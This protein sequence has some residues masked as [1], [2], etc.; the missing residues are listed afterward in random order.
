L[1][2][3]ADTEFDL[4][5]LTW[6]KD[7]IDQ[8]LTKGLAA[9]AEFAARPEDETP[10][11]HAQTHIHQAAGAVQIVGLDGAITVM[12]EVER[13]LTLLE[14]PAPDSLTARVEAIGAACRRLSRYLDDLTEGE[15]PLTLKLY[16]EYE[17][18]MKLRGSD[19]ASPTDLFF[20]D[21][22]RR[23]KHLGQG[24]GQ[25][26]ADRGP[27]FLR[28]QRRAYEQGLLN[29]LRG[30]AQGLAAMRQAIQEIEDAHASSPAGAFWWTVG[31]FLTSV[32]DQ[33]LL[34]GYTVKQLCARIDLQIRRFV[35][36]STKVADRLRREVLY[37][38]AISVPISK[39]VE[40]VQ[41]L[42]G[43]PAMLLQKVEPRQLDLDRFQ[44]VLKRA[45]EL[46]A[47]I[48]DLWLRFTSGRREALA[49]IAQNLGELK[50]L[51]AALQEPSLTSLVGTLEGVAV[52]AAQTGNVPDALAIEFATGLLLTEDAIGHF[53]KLS[54][55]FPR[56]VESMRRR[57]DLAQRGVVSLPTAEEDLLDDM[58]RR[59][60]ERM[61]LS[62]V[63][64]EIQGN[65][66]QIEK[67]LDAFFRDASERGELAGLGGYARQIQ[68]ALQMLGLTQASEL[69]ELCQKQIDA[70]A[71][72]ALASSDELELLAESLS[73]LGFYIEAVEQQR[74]DAGRLLEP[75]LRRRLGLAAEPAPESTVQSTEMDLVA[76]REDLP[77]ALARFRAAPQDPALRAELNVHLQALKNDA[78][79][80]ADTAFSD[81]A[82]R[83]LAALHDERTS[84]ATLL[85]ALD[86]LTPEQASLAPAPSAETMR[87]LGVGESKLDAELSEIF[88]TEAGEVLATVSEHLALCENDPQDRESLRA[89]RR[90]F[91]T[92]K[93]SGRMVGL[94]EL[95][96][97]AYMVEK[98]LNRWLD[99]ERP[100]V[101]ELLAMLHK[102]ENE[103]R[104][105]VG[106]LQRQG[107]V[108]VE[109]RALAAAISAL[110]AAHPPPAAPLVATLA[111]PAAAGKADAASA[112]T[113]AAEA[114]MADAAVAELAEPAAPAGI[115]TQIDLPPAPVE[116][117]IVIGEVRISPSL[118][119]ILLEE[120]AQH[121]DTLNREHAGLQFS[122]RAKPTQ[123]MVRAA[124]TLSG[125]YR[126]AGFLPVAETAHALENALLSLQ[127]QSVRPDPALPTLADAV[128]AL[129]ELVDFIGMRQPFGTAAL[130]RATDVQAELA[131]LRE[132]GEGA[133]VDSETLAAQA[134]LADEIATPL[135][136]PA[137]A[138]LLEVP[139]ES[140]EPAPSPV[141]A[142]P[143]A[144]AA[145]EIQPVAGPVVTEPVAPAELQ[146]API[147]ARESVD[148]AKAETVQVDPVR[149]RAELL[150]SV[151]DELDPQLLRV[152]L[153]EAQELFPRA[154]AVLR[155]W[156]R[157]PQ[158]REYAL[159]LRRTLHTLKGGARMAGAMRLGELT[160]L[161][162]SR[163]MVGES[164]VAPSPELFDA[165]DNDL[166][167]QAS[168]LDQLQSWTPG[169][170]PKPEAE[171]AQSA[172]ERSAAATWHRR[173]P[174]QPL[175]LLVEPPSSAK[176]APVAGDAAADAVVAVSE[177]A[178]ESDV[179]QH[180]MVRVRSEVIDRLVNETGE[181][182]IA[183]A[184]IEGEL[185]SLKSNLLELTNSVIRLRGQVR[186]IEI[187]A[188]TQIQSRMSQVQE[189]EAFDPLEFDRYTRYQEL[190]R[191]LAEGV[192]DVATVQQALL[193]NLDDA[194]AALT[195]QAR[196]SR[197]V[198]QQLLAVRTVPFASLSER[199]Y[200]VL[201]QT[202]K[203]LEKKANLEIRGGQTELDR[204]VLEKLVAPLEHLLRNALDH[205]I[206]DP[207]ARLAAAKPEIGE[208][209]IAV[210]QEGNEIALTLSDDGR[211]LPLD[212][213]KAKAIASGL[214][215]AQAEPT[216]AQ[217]IEAI[218]APGISTALQ[219]TQISGRGIG[220]D[221]VKN[222]ITG[223]GGRVEVATTPG[224][225][226]VFTL[227]LPLT[228]AVTQAVL[229]R[230]GGRIHA[231]P[232]ALVEQVQQV[233]ADALI[234]LYV[235]REVRW[236][237]RVYPFFYL[238]QLL[239]DTQQNPDP[240][241][242]NP[243][244]LLKSANQF[245]AIHV[246]AMLGNQE[247]VIKNIGAQLARLP[248][249]AG[250]TVL[251]TGEIVLILN[252]V[253]L[254]ARQL[255]ASP[256]TAADAAK[257]E[258]PVAGAGEAAPAAQ[259]AMLHAPY[260][261]VVDDSLTV[262]KI[263][264]RLLI[265]EGF[266]VGT[267]RDGV[268][269]LQ[270]LADRRPDVILLDIEMPRMDGF[271]FAN[272]VKNDPQFK[273]IPI[274]MITSRTAAKH[275][276]RAAEIGVEV[277]IGKPFQ[278]EELLQNIRKFVSAATAVAS[279]A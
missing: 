277:Y 43:L 129:A 264:S 212:E 247:I 62:Q 3:A 170:A 275:R 270:L 21:L 254:L 137:L 228:L 255:R 89:I 115:G 166:D 199:L 96:E 127:H 242:H 26:A 107:A 179:L 246:D 128:V 37:H 88:L 276:A 16:P 187:Q 192:N 206:E 81:L 99:E 94:L 235:A 42:Y 173:Q 241:R 146:P 237:N 249:L 84:T 165:L 266:E 75:F 258:L 112:A 125:I 93:G 160:H 215:A 55:Q 226:T 41:A 122:P 69:L 8:A 74:P 9:L 223:L 203:E 1:A 116:H 272:T 70:Y 227:Y 20:P 6:V 39:R 144:Y 2:I 79:L 267:A 197:D 158:Q 257:A 38:V 204:G 152:F 44:P 274:I 68:G 200:R 236:Q 172:A 53:A 176:T 233:K 145:L 54:D 136:E 140:A 198:Q 12:E 113:A 279:V 168:L 196:L 209:S 232:A 36:G 224:R 91:H 211:G 201:R 78:D 149:A 164:A 30:G 13:H 157:A 186:E 159:D 22:A 183:R 248:G 202:A 217:L 63:A 45:Q 265:R 101:P 142:E 109:D 180:V 52:G 131:R 46:V 97:T 243:V 4:G 47:N 234:G 262:R 171:H 175:Q 229:V 85:A 139:V 216:E 82:A 151:R 207:A 143:Q 98:V 253:Q 132:A 208:I 273:S 245:L 71:A 72:G 194:D 18:L 134:A 161:M 103:F 250:A 214:F 106:E 58:A 213:I 64:R 260:V 105:W 104:R 155:D 80:V 191:S 147:A 263:T 133:A 278:E 222:E 135:A 56:Q 181:V 60:Q 111:A 268:D 239:G 195:A 156:R 167:Q 25:P 57:L 141:P 121:L 256:L 126:T 251:G 210:R 178:G 67:V 27:A 184:R 162:E 83:A 76:S 130:Q 123:A 118:Y 61:L 117:E 77:A 5:P 14:S 28:T 154:G 7:E 124:H 138:G 269:A 17:A 193:K 219:V 65:L 50:A 10:L 119:T 185:R 24:A 90:G 225:G 19:S 23:P 92:L 120:T 110:E 108:Q 205:G 114:Q 221:V 102:A 169:A 31:A 148:A 29:W 230:A 59:A 73:G 35:E 177:P 153:E 87:L 261:L 259:P 163:L 238:P 231:L 240:Q 271:E 100:A 86:E 48:K 49:P 11:R 66:R 51:G 244:L 150:A 182:S 188:E 252:P 15:P 34:T 218:F 220:M 189:V 95:G 33:G 32:A 40:E 190:T 174:G